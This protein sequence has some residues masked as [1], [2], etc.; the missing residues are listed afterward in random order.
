MY[1]SKLRYVLMHVIINRQGMVRCVLE[2]VNIRNIIKAQQDTV[3]VRSKMCLDVEKI[4]EQLNRLKHMA[5]YPL[6]T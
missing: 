6:V 5:F 1:P 2:L 3:L 4:S